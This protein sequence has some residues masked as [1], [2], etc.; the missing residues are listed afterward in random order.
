MPGLYRQ[1]DPRE[2]DDA[3][4]AAE[5]KQSIENLNAEL[6]SAAEA[7]LSVAF[8]VTDENPDGDRLGYSQ[9]D[10]LAVLRITHYLP[11]EDS[12]G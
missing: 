2:L 11:K 8:N 10:N 7:G 6:R 5:I 12:N 3:R 1:Y 4:I 9:I